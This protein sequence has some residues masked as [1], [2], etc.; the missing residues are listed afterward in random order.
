MRMKCSEC[1][2]WGGNFPLYAQEGFPYPCWLSHEPRLL[3]NKSCIHKYREPLTPFVLW[4]LLGAESL[5]QEEIIEAAGRLL[6]E[7][8][9]ELSRL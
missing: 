7:Q 4:F 5:F 6:K 9:G 2:F 3:G 8:L 1:P